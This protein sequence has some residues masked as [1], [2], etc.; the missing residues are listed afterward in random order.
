MTPQ[1]Y[2]ASQSPAPAQ[3]DTAASGRQ[4]NGSGSTEGRAVSCSG[5]S[6]SSELG[7][8][9]VHIGRVE[10]IPAIRNQA[11]TTSALNP[12]DPW[13]FTR[14]KPETEREFLASLPEALF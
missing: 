2:Q 10:H 12:A 13:P 14:I 9:G 3:S 5:W 11:R 7:L 1:L 6:R 4:I 8:V